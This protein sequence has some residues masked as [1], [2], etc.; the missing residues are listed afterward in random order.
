[1]AVAAGPRH[2]EL[3][4]HSLVL[5]QQLAEVEEADS[6]KEVQAQLVDQVVEVAQ[7]EGSQVDQRLQAKATMVVQVIQVE[8][9][10]SV[11]VAV[12]ELVR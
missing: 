6:H 8:V 5:Q 1:L 11:V 2:Q 3:T 9:H 12:V 10:H 7:V 4:H